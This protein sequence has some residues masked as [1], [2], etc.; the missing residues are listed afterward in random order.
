[1]S[2]RGACWLLPALLVAG[3]ASPATTSTSPP[4]AAASSTSGAAGLPARPFEL[5][6]TSTDPCSLLTDTQRTSLGVGGPGAAG[7]STGAGTPAPTCHW[8]RDTPEPIGSWSFGAFVDQDAESVLDP[9]AGARVI[10]I[11]GFGT[12]EISRYDSAPDRTCQLFVDTAP[13]QSLTVIYDYSGTQKSTKQIVCD[14]A[15]T[16]ARMAIATLTEQAGR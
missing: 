15:A 11:G 9:S 10:D 7:T 8:F 14:R 16:A 3:C 5:P 4:V 1:M 12:V 13:G 6:V 2:R